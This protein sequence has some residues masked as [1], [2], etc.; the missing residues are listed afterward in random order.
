MACNIIRNENGKLVNV[1]A[2]NG[3]NSKLFRDI[4]KL[5]YDKE[6]ALKK[7]ANTYTPTF[8]QWF[9]EG[10]VDSNGE[11]KISIIDDQPVFTADD[12]TTKHA[13]ENLGTYISKKDPS[14]LLDSIK[15][16]FDLV[17]TDGTVKNIPLS[18]DV[19]K[20]QET[21]EKQYPGVRAFILKD[22]GGD[23]IKLDITPH[24][25]V[26]NIYHQVQET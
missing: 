24:L 10:V 4:V 15:R 19:F 22:V 6:T 7:W 5:G 1:T 20:I 18:R 26:D 8:K 9:G 3:K 11:P 25:D 16:R 13:T 17:K 21:I 14:P 23:Y 12:N 2:E